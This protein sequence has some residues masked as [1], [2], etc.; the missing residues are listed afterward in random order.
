[1]AWSRI[2]NINRSYDQQHILSPAPISHIP[3]SPSISLP[4]S[5]PLSLHPSL[6]LP[7]SPALHLSFLPP[8][9]SPIP[10]SIHLALLYIHPF[11]SLPPSVHL[12]L[13]FLSPSLPSSLPPPSLPPPP[14]ANFFPEPLGL[15]TVALLAAIYSANLGNFRQFWEI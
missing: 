1:M 5:L 8:S 3:T 2:G 7:P 13:I 4:P 6:P 12:S 15:C 9:I 14:P 10:P 11:L